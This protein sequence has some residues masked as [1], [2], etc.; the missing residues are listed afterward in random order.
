M[1]FHCLLMCMIWQ[2]KDSLLALHSEGM[3]V[4]F[5][6]QVYTTASNAVRCYL[7]VGR[8]VS[9]QRSP[10]FTATSLEGEQA[11]QKVRGVPV[12]HRREKLPSF[13]PEAQTCFH[14][15]K[16]SGK[17]GVQQC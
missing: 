3:Y 5:Q 12:H 8:A 9:Q 15:V 11:A 4:A 7:H 2:L 1:D 6:C 17:A 14:S 10:L 13:C 16:Q